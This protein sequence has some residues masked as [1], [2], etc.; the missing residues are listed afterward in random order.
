MIRVLVADDHAVVRAGIVALLDDVDGIEVV[1]Q[2]ADGLAAVEEARRLRP[3]L[4]VLDVRMPGATGDVATARIR[5]ELPGTR[6]LILTTYESD[7]T[8][9]AAIEAGAS[10]Y[11]LKAAPAEELVEGVRSVA[12][13]ETALSPAI[14]AQL[15]ARLRAPAPA[16]LTPRELDVLRLVAAGCSNRVIGE[17]LFIGEA[18]VKSHL[19]RVFEKLGVHDR[20]RAVTLAMERGLL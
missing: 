1:G 10:G 16:E 5:A 14:A 20:T 18:T 6:V 4:V 3:D 15:V 13:G 17:R 7:S 8:I 12:R 9:I 19:L 2:A 11:L